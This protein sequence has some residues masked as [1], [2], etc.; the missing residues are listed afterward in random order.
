MIFHTTFIVTYNFYVT[1]VNLVRFDFNIR[2]R[3]YTRK[4]ENLHLTLENKTLIEIN[5]IYLKLNNHKQELK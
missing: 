3:S 5:K 4:K 1:T 2:Y